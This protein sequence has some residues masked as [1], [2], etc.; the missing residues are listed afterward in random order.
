MSSLNLEPLTVQLQTV[1]TE[2]IK[3]GA[4]VERTIRATHL[5]CRLRNSHTDGGSVIA[6]FDRAKQPSLTSTPDQLGAHPQSEIHI[7]TNRP[8]PINQVLN[9]ARCITVIR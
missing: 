2:V 7:T 5:C 1:Q 4:G 9:N 3:S 6:R 8:E